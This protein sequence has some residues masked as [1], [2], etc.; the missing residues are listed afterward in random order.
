MLS[1]AQYLPRATDLEI[2]GGQSKTGTQIAELLQ[3]A[4]DASAAT[5]PDSSFHVEGMT[6][7]AYACSRLRPTRPTQLVQLRQAETIG[8]VDDD[9]VRSQE[10]RG[11]FR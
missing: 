1:C 11:R 7:Y 2:G 3:G 6:K 10:C 4:S 5:S 8:T 9:R